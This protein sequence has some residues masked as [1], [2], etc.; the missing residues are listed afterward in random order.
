MNS[1]FIRLWDVLEIM[2]TLDGQ[3]KPFRF[4]MKYITA[5]RLQGTGGEIIE[6]KDVCKCSGKTKQGKPIFA[7]K[8]NFPSNDHASK[9]PRHWT[10]S[11]RN[12]LLPNGQ[13][14]KV[15]IRLIIE[16]NN[17]KVCY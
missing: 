16:F 8:K 2:D 4:Q 9:D 3:G 11:T 14:R 10:H 5:N 1:S 6:L 12:I 17:K 13:I 7:S 15:H